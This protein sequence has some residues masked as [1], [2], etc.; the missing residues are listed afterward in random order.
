M[1]HFHKEISE[2]GMVGYIE[3]LRDLNPTQVENACRRSLREVDRMPSVAHIRGKVF[4]SCVSTRPDYLDEPP[5][6]E[7]DRIEADKFSAKLRETLGKM[8]IKEEKPYTVFNE[9]HLPTV[10]TEGY[11]RWLE[12]QN[13]KDEMERKKGLSPLPR[14]EEER[15]AMFCALPIEE[16]RRLKW[17]KKTIKNT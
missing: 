2:L 4:D 5:M 7:E 9:T 3:G 8:E 14:S 6:T 12:E 1:E 13:M 16:R 15:R 17:T 11:L 10:D